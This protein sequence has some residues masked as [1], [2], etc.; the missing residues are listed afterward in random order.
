VSDEAIT[1]ARRRVLERLK[2]TGPA[3]AGELAGDLGLTDVAVRQHLAALEGAGLVESAKQPPAGRGRP[4]RLWSLTPVADSFF[5][6]RHADLTV[7]LID[8]TRRAFGDDGLMRIVK[9][10]ARDQ[11]SLYRRA[12]PASASL[13]K[14][15]EALARQRT[16]EGYMAE[17]VQEKPGIYLLI[18]HHC[19]ICD[20]AKRCSGL[21]AAELDVFRRTLGRGVIVE[22]TT[23]LLSGGDRCVYRINKAS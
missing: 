10:R 17:V 4:S 18:E 5:P 12:V 16:A 7:D 23:H 14:R 19:P 22:R 11:L 9:V 2:R 13:R 1:G 15:V 6:D 3:T 8:A 20:A 21:C